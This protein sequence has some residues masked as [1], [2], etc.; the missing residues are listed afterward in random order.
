[1]M[2][3]VYHGPQ[4]LSDIARRVHRLT[5]IL[6]AGLALLG[7]K[8][9][10]EYFFD[11]LSVATARPAAEVHAAALAAGLNLRVIDDGRVGVSLDETCEQAAVEALWA[12]FAAG[13][14]LPDFAALAAS[15]GDQLP[16][17]LLRTSAFLRH[18]VFNR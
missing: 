5:A 3:A 10:Q 14:A 2:Y 11:T 12:V 16:Q 4:G 8:V 17:A 13:Q 6:A 15:V 18:E 1:S 9:E 7:H